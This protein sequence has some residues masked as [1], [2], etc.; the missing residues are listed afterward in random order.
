MTASSLRCSSQRMSSP[1]GTRSPSRRLP[2]LRHLSPSP[3][4]S[5]TTIS[6]RPLSLSWAMRLDPINPAPPVTSNIKTSRYPRPIDPFA[7]MSRNDNPNSTSS[8]PA[9]DR[10]ELR[11]YFDFEPRIRESPVPSLNCDSNLTDQAH[12]NPQPR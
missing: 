2:R 7:E 11:G 9:G 8:L 5:L 1:G 10:C 4:V 12:D 3:S 6:L